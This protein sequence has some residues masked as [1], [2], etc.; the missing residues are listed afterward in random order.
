[1]TQAPDPTDTGEIIGLRATFASWPGKGRMTQ[2]GRGGPSLTRPAHTNGPDTNKDVDDRSAGPM[3]CELRPRGLARAG[4][5]DLAGHARAAGG[6]RPRH[7]QRALGRGGVLVLDGRPGWSARRTT[8][9]RPCAA[10][11]TSASA[12]S[13]SATRRTSARSCASATRCCRSCADLTHVPT[14]VGA[15]GRELLSPRSQQSRAS[16]ITFEV[17][18]SEKE[19]H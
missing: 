4:W 8:W 3:A 11:P 16:Y 7:D 5:T 14:V 17:R 19:Y 2:K 12:T 18:C 15:G 13:C 9:P 6:G 1:M 10:T